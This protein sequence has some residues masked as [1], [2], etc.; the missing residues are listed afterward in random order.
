[1]KIKNYILLAVI[2]SFASTAIAKE[3][4][5]TFAKDVAPIIYSKCSS[6]HRAGQV[7]PFSLMSFEEVRKHSAEILLVLNKH[8]MPPWKAGP[9]SYAFAGDRRLSDKHTA[10]IT[11]WIKKRYGAGCEDTAATEI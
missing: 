4:K 2:I 1:M 6:C 7:G 8:Q 10:V 9:S 5:L 3:T 11:Q